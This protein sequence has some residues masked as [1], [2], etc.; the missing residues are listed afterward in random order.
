MAIRITIDIFSGRPNPVLELKG[1]EERT[2]LDL[3]KSEGRL[4][5]T[6]RIEDIPVLGYRGM[7]IEYS[8]NRK[9][10]PASFNVLGDQ[11]LAGK[12]AFFLSDSAAF[13][14]FVCGLVPKKLNLP[15]P[16]I[17]KFE[18]FLRREMLWRKGLLWPGDFI[19]SLVSPCNCGPIYEPEWWNDGA[20]R[21]RNNN[22]YNYGCNYRTDTF[23]QPGL[24]AGAMYPLPITGAGVRAAAIRDMLIDSPNAN[25]VCP[26]K[27]HLV[28]LVIAP[29]AAFNDFHWYRK[30]S[31]GYW[32][33]KPGPTQ[34]TNRDNA[35][36]LIVDPR[37]AD[38]GFYKQFTT[39]MVVMHG[40]IKI[41]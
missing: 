25:N 29:D 18:K 17:P 33:H 35:G 22:C 11:L 13:E 12:Q 24:A 15:R 6:E 27:G 36:K 8:G 34:V 41:R 4:K 10:V 16:Q 40:H 1:S 31:D 30:G 28:A 20:S 39:F 23:A 9:S 38:R 26:E 14:D 7:K 32:S 21:Q 37:T 3:L 19:K 5:T 2:A